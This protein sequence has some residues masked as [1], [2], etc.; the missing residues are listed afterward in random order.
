MHVLPACM[1]VHPVPAV[2]RGQGRVLS[3]LVLGLQVVV[4]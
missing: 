2:P 3:L 1:S 4:S